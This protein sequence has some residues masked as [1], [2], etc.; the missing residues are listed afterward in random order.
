MRCIDCAYHTYERDEHIRNGAITSMC[1]SVDVFHVI[2]DETEEIDCKAFRACKGES[3]YDAWER[4]TGKKFQDLLREAW[5]HSEYSKFFRE[6][7]GCFEEFSK[8]MTRDMKLQDAA[9][10]WQEND[11][12]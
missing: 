7:Y 12:V 1:K 3:A 11:Y 2:V 6:V 9:V 5:E 10:C 8:C 4:E